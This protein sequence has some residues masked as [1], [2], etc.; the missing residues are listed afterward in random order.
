MTHAKM[1]PHRC[2]V[3]DGRGSMPASFYALTTSADP[4]MESC[5]SCDKGIVWAMV[6]ATDVIEIR[7][8]GNGD[9]VT[10]PTRWSMP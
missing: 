8:E 5:R 7:E 2:P 3:C 9:D 6:I 1:T 4:R 10:L